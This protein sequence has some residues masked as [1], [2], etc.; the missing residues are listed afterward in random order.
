MIQEKNQ[1]DKIG[2]NQQTTK[3]D[4]EKHLSEFAAKIENIYND[5]QTKVKTRLDRID[6]EV[7]QIFDSGAEQARQQFEDY[8]D[9]KMSAYKFDRYLSQLPEGPL[10]W[11]RD[12][13]LNLPP[14]VNQFY[15]EGKNL[16]ISKMETVI[17]NVAKVT[18]KGLLEAKAIISQGRVQVQQEFEALPENIKKSGQ[19]AVDKIQ[20]KFDTLRKSV[21]D[22]R[23][24]LIDSLAKKYADNLQKVDDRINQMKEENKGLVDKAKDAIEGVINTILEL[25]NMLLG[26]FSRAAAAIDKIIKDPIGFLRNL[27]KGI[28]Q[29]LEKF[30]A[31]IGA[32]LQKGLMDWL[33]GTLGKAGI[34]MPKSFDLKGILG[35]V[36]QVL[37]LT[38]ANIRKRAVGILGEKTVKTLETAAEIFKILI[39]QG[40]AGLW[41]YIKEKIGDLK[42]T[43]I[44]GIKSFLIE[45]VIMAGITW[46][47]GLLNPASAFVKAAK[48]IYDIVMF[49]VNKGSQIISLVNAIIDSVSAIADGAIG[50]AATAVE[51]ALAK[52]VP[53]A[54][55]FLAS[56]LGLDGIDEKIKKIIEKI[57]DPI[58]KAID[59]VIKKA[60]ELVKAI[61][62]ALGFGKEEKKED[63]DPEHQAKIDAVLL[64]IDEEEKK[65]LEEDKITQEN[66]EKVAKTVKSNH[67]VFK[68]LTVENIGEEWVYQY[69]G[70]AQ[71]KK[72]AKI[73]KKHKFAV[74]NI[75][76][77]DK[78]IEDKLKKIIEQSNLDYKTEYRGKENPE[79]NKKP[80]KMWRLFEETVGHA[81]ENKM[82]P[83]IEQDFTTP[84]M[85]YEEYEKQKTIKR[86]KKRI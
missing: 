64:E 20:S 23:D 61:G 60:V 66:A 5:T 29:G 27:V 43:V 48:A 3:S 25:K 17:D 58:N 75:T 72:H 74:R 1:F 30:I 76:I 21:D 4:D 38:Y 16:F 81:L 14:E 53:V 80:M 32:H 8:V 59:W 22:K 77:N 83:E 62:K 7:N 55:G 34:T 2:E 35:L 86:E 40:P 46:I 44:E 68:S 70:S 9:S 78:E 67:P 63:D 12:K 24:Q 19:D 6:T 54:I 69:I 28:K 10:L 33:F 39:T 36:L 18:E 37:G 85:S 13:F 15:T 73:G 50:V 11:I 56:L 47:I 71:G 51:N 45:K 52:A 42:E 26:V 82:I 65:Y 49:F 84:G 57:Q 41:E 31:N 79:A